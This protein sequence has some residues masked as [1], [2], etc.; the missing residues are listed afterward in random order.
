MTEYLMRC[1]INIK[2]IPEHIVGIPV[3]TLPE[4]E[5]LALQNAANQIQAHKEHNPITAESEALFEFEEEI[6]EQGDPIK[7]AEY[8]LQ[9]DS[10]A[11]VR[12]FSKEQDIS[13]QG[14]YP[15]SFE[16]VLPKAVIKAFYYARLVHKSSMLS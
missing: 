14:I 8:T 10:H 3:S 12:Q 1:E 2:A 16:A 13:D 9:C 5:L 4:E 7:L 15:A 6:V 11:V